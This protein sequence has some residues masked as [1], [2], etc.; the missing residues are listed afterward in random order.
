MFDN[1]TKKNINTPP[2]A[3][4]QPI[5]SGPS[6]VAPPFQQPR[7]V[8]NIPSN[9]Q[10]FNVPRTS[11]GSMGNYNLQPSQP[12]NPA[13]VQQVSG[14]NFTPPPAPAATPKYNKSYSSIPMTQQNILTEDEQHEMIRRE[15]L[16]K[17][18]KI[19]LLIIAL[20]VLGSLI[21]GGIWLYITIQP[22]S[23]ADN[24]NANNDQIK[25]TNNYSLLNINSSTDTDAD[26][27]TDIEEMQ[28]GTSLNVADTD[29]DG[30]LDGAEV[31]GGYNPLG[32]GQLINK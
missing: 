31:E 5:P 13:P 7:P 12:S 18:Q 19:I 22:F 8:S 14:N 11:S 1:Q 2:V 26:G 29:G 10:N 32:E 4:F 17:I 28:Y 6:P 24:A 20:I 3:P 23:N 27:L 16:S 9:T 25:N 21:G 15:K 30:Y